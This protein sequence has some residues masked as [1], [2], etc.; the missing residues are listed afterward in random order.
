[1]PTTASARPTEANAASV[2]TP[3]CGATVFPEG[4]SAGAAGAGN[5]LG[6]VEFGFHVGNVALD[7]VVEELPRAV[8]LLHLGQDSV[9]QG[10]AGFPLFARGGHPVA[11]VREVAAESGDVRGVT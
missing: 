7:E 11:E 10:R 6:A 9:H 2:N 5:P 8:L 1:M 3:N 4:R